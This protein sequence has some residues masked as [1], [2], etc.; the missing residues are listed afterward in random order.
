MIGENTSDTVLPDPRYGV[1]EAGSVRA[2]VE[3]APGQIPVRAEATLL[4]ISQYGA[5]L[6]ASCSLQI[7][8]LVTLQIEVAEVERIFSLPAIVRW[9]QPADTATWRLGCVFTGALPQAVLD[10]LSLLGYMERRQD[11]RQVVDVAARARWELAKEDFPIRIVSVSASGLRIC[12]E[13]EGKIGERLLLQLKEDEAEPLFVH[14]R[15]VWE[16]EEDGRR[17]IGCRLASRED[18]E[19][20]R[21]A[22]RLAPADGPADTDSP[23]SRSILGLAVLIA[24][25]V[26]L[27]VVWLHS[28]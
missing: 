17:V 27:L 22:L 7:H 16:R 14:S 20:L 15:A 13:E 26:I 10:E 2:R 9:R 21:S 25:S 24:I 28:R 8:E 5:K 3:R 12:C 11:R 4:D 18:Y 1:C 23:R 6:L 19:M